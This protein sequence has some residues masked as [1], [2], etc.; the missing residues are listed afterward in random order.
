MYLQRGFGGAVGLLVLS[1][2]RP[3]AEALAAF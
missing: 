2:G 1:R 3:T